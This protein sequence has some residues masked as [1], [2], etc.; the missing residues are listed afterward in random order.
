MLELHVWG[1]A[2][3]LPS[4]DSHCLAAIAYLQQAVPAGQWV[5]M[6]SSNLA[7]SPTYELP[8]LRDGEIWIGG[9]R[10]I[11]HYIAQ[12]SSGKWGLDVGLSEQ[13]IADCVAWSSFLDS[14]AQPLLD[15]SLYVST[16][17]YTAV[18]R[19]I[20]STIQSFPL[21][22]IVP[23]ALRSAA[24]SRS[25]HL[26]LASLEVDSEATPSPSSSTPQRLRRSQ[27]SVSG[28]LAATPESAA[29]IRLDALASKFFEPL[30]NLRA[31]KRYFVS[32]TQLTSLDCLALGY[33]SLMLIPELPQPWLAK[34]MR[35][36]FPRLSA[37]TQ[38]LRTE[39][40]GGAVG[41]NDVFGDSKSSGGDHLPWKRP[42]SKLLGVGRIFLSALIDGVPGLSQIR[43][44]N[45]IRYHEDDTMDTNDWNVAV[46]T[47]STVFVA[48]VAGFS[49]TFCNG[50]LGFGEK[51]EKRELGNHFSMFGAN[52]TL[53]DLYTSSRLQKPKRE[54]NSSE[55]N[56]LS[57]TDLVRLGLR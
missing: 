21:P 40:F 33:L 11:F 42:P 24:R 5:V 4:I 29:Q 48:V 7:L 18:T 13:E 55:E 53:G 46:K 14:N 57:T 8:A 56:S 31:K 45:K 32:E 20:Y 9:F 47:I 3:G 44:K 41:M 12:C 39:I 6:A 34:T 17:N 37:W 43:R 54:I 38:E 16:E 52:N 36:R 1:P 19:P 23:A 2:F 15:L 27:N 35:Q 26:G 50:I 49:W 25:A 30:E 51:M 10:N 28:M 22:Y